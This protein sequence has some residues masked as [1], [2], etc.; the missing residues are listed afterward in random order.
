MFPILYENIESGIIPQHHG[1]GVLSDAISCVIEQ[2]RN[3]IYELTMEYAES[4]IHAED[5]A[6]RRIIKAKPN[7]TDDPQLFRI[8]R[9]GKV[10]NGVFTVY[11][12]HISYDLSGVLISSGTA[13]SA[14]SACL[15][16]QNAATGYTITTDKTVTANFKITEPS[17]VRSWFGGKEGSFLDVFGETELKYN[18][19][20]IQFLLHAGQDRGV[21]IRYG[22]NLLELSQEIGDSVYTH[23]VAF[24]KNDDVMV[25]GNKV[26]T[27]LV[28]DMEKTLILDVS[29]DYENPPTNQQLT[30][31]TQNYISNN[32]L[33]VPSNNI[34]LDFVQSGELSNRV[35]LCDTVTVYYEALGISRTQVKCIRT[36]WDCIREKYIETEF[37]DATGSLA[38]SIIETN[39]A[40]AE[41]P[42]STDM[43]YAIRNATQLITGNLGGYVVLHD[44]DRD[45]EPDEILIMNTPDIST[46][47]AVWRWNK[48]GLGY[49]TSYDGEYG[50]A[51]TS[52]GAIVADFIT[53][54]TMSGNRVRAGIIESNN[55]QLIINLDTGTI[56]APAI[57][58]NGTNVEDRLEELEQVSVVTRYALSNSGTVIPSTF[59]L[60][61]PTAPTEQQ[62]YLW[63]R[64]IYTYADG[65]TNISYGISVKGAKGANGA[66]G[67]GL[68]I[69]GNYDTIEELIEDHPTG[70][71]GQAYMIGTDLVVW[72]TKTN[73]WEDVGRIQGASGM[74][75]LWLAIENDDD[76][77]S[78]NITYT[79][80]L[81]KGVTDVTTTYD[82][83]FV[84]Q[85]VKESGV[86]EIANNTPSITV[87]RDSADYGGTI[88]CICIAILTDEVLED[89]G[90]NTIQ[91]YSGNDI[92][93]IGQNVVKLI[94]EAAI[95]KPYA[96]ESQFQVLQDEISSRVT[97]T[98]FNSLED[99]VTTQGTLIQQNAQ[100]ILLKADTT[101]V[102]A[103]LN[104]KMATDMSNKASSILIDSGQIRFDSNSIVINSD[105]FTLDA[106]GNASFGGNLSAATLVIGGSPVGIGTAISN[107]ESDAVSTAA[108]DATA[109]ANA[110]ISTAA[111]DATTKAN[112]AKT[113]AISTA[114]ADATTKANNALASSKTYT[115]TGLAGKVGNNEIRTKFAA[116]TH[117][118]T[119][120][121]GTIAFASNT[122]IVDSTQFKLDA[123]GNATFKGNLSA[124]TINIGG[125][126]KNI[127]VAIDDA[128]N[129]AVT[130]AVNLAAED[131]TTKANNAQATAISTAASDATTKANNA[132][133]QAISTAATDATNK[134]NRA[135]TN[136]KT[137]AASDATAKANNAESN[138]KTWAAADAT[139]KADNAENNAIST[140]NS[141]TDTGLSTKVGNTEIR[142]KF[143]ADDHSITIQSGTIAFTSNTL[144]VDATNL[145]ITNDGKVTAK[146]FKAKNGFRVVDDNEVAL[147]IVNK[148]TYGG[149]FQVVNT[150]GNAIATLWAAEY[151]GAFSVGYG[152]GT[153]AVN[154]FAGVNG[155]IFRLRD[156]SNHLGFEASSDSDGGLLK[157]MNSS[158][159][160]AQQLAVTSEGGGTSFMN[161]DEG[162][163]TIQENGQTGEIT[164]VRVR[165]TS[166]RKVKENIKPIEDAEKI[167]ELQAVS[168]DYKNKNLGTDRRGFIAE[169]VAEVLPNLVSEETE[170]TPASLDYISMIPYLQEIVKQQQ[171]EID[172][173]KAEIEKLKGEN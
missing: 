109:K 38:D 156:A 106:D 113:Q 86:T 22:K 158:G 167:L 8:D 165:Q 161:D 150:A 97:Q 54:G 104:S 118:I 50:T 101:T 164:C 159:R 75:G 72:N 60:A 155:G 148:T 83:V 139:T 19:F 66:D 141:Y 88:R 121:S 120:Q 4:G 45:G 149:Y 153:N 144:S 136:A 76:G 43:D 90:Y 47:T 62:P 124:A 57:T 131:A 52:D 100:Q 162:T 74:D 157:I 24:F 172:I 34:V 105:Q 168:F 17:S 81:L 99:T 9:I 145:Q 146:Q 67:A 28:L 15:L 166:S 55:H 16:L 68:Q 20:N 134:A 95:Y 96:I 39:R 143:A 123:Q 137:W 78:T 56:S 71:A 115:D 170:D 80:R 29:G 114:S 14:S 73:S 119:I 26:S 112:N 84:W 53:A 35:D 135:E 13:S 32:N 65:Q 94:G 138:A 125:S 1:L 36:K 77:A 2:E 40:I 154:A 23:V 151:G 82:A 130:N 3:G 152:N 31:Y 108:S 116:D 64:T 107:A 37:G 69:L 63:S 87:T 42:S 160:I 140:A 59:P 51:I 92:Q 79:A 93:I 126:S 48:N 30:T 25:M 142:T 49:A 44:A 12:K 10:M 117:S 89:Y 133:T 103:G 11:A 129:N 21:T 91:D 102:D 18:N 132:K 70:T 122:L 127:G 46:A 171:K 41:K 98:E 33:T 85:M 147:A 111:S 173:L 128:E 6:L 7:F 27:G 5:L 110:A 58:L 169:D 61:N 163:K